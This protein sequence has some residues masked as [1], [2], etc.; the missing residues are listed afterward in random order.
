MRDDAER[1]RR[2][3]VLIREQR[4]IRGQQHG[5]QA[6]RNGHAAAG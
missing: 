1:L 3:G 6:Q 4:P 5:E 2:I